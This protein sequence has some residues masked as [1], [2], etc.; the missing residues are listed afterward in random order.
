[1]PYSFDSLNLP[2]NPI[3]IEQAVKVAA[4][5]ES[6]LHAISQLRSPAESSEAAENDVTHISQ[7]QLSGS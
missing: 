4:L 1:M 6:L 3:Q 7:K 5:V 2:L